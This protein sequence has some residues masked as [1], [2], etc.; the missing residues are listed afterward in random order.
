M[1]IS[2]KLLINNS[3]FSSE[4]NYSDDFEEE[5]VASMKDSPKKGETNKPQSKA[6]SPKKPLE[7]PTKPLEIPKKPFEV[8]KKSLDSSRKPTEPSVKSGD[9]PRASIEQGRTSVESPSKKLDFPEAGL[10][11]TTD[12]KGTLKKEASKGKLELTE[13]SNS[14]SQGKPSVPDLDENTKKRIEMEECMT[15]L[16]RNLADANIRLLFIQFCEE[17]VNHTRILYSISIGNCQIERGTQD[18]RS[19][20]ASSKHFGE[21]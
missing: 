7:L 19:Q 15:G 1:K 14:K 5:A 13:G 8:A 12:L 9:S 20:E 21:R 4:D 3:H 11:S 16:R 17:K 6:E 10:R 2:S 18:C